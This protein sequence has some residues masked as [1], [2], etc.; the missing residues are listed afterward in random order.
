MTER[1]TLDV[2]PEEI[3]PYALRKVLQAVSERAMH[4]VIPIPQPTEPPPTPA[5]PGIALPVAG[6]G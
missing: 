1:D 4:D 2:Q 6:S 5:E 3:T